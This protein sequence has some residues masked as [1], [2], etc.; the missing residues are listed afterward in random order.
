MKILVTGGTGYL[1]RRLIERLCADKHY[2]S[3]FHRASSDLSPLKGL[4]VEF[5]AGELTSVDDL[6]RAMKGVEWVFHV[7]GNTSPKRS[8]KKAL[9][10]TNVFGTRAVV[11]A[12]IRAQVKRL[13]HTSSIAAIGFPMHGEGNE[14]TQFLKPSGSITYFLT[15]HLA[16]KEV[17]GGI[18]QGLDAVFANPGFILGPG[19]DDFSSGGKLILRV[20][21]QKVPLSPPGGICLIDVDDVVEGHIRLATRGKRGERYILG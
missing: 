13:I 19:D 21:K 10:E 5:R 11:A 15:K 20:A 14:Q 8:D 2:V 6:T 17:Q 9:M 4:P 18:A 3:L 7:A 16:E 1:G 12:A